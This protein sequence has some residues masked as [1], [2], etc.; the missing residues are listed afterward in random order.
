MNFWKLLL[1][2]N[3]I[4]IF[5]IYYLFLP[6]E[7]DRETGTHQVFMPRLTPPL[8]WAQITGVHTRALA[9]PGKS[10]EV[11]PRTF[12]VCV[13]LQYHWATVWPY[14]FLQKG[15]LR[16]KNYLFKDPSLPD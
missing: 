7:R 1:Y 3:V 5:H 16:L 8:Q 11:N 2:A 12:S 13:Q 9:C 14:M 6:E 10:Q 15:K 4:S